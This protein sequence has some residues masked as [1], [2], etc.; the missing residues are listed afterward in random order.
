MGLDAG[1]RAEIGRFVLPLVARQVRGWRK[2]IATVPGP[3]VPAH[4]CPS[5]EAIEQA[6]RA[7][8]TDLVLP[9]FDHLGIDV[10]AARGWAE[11]GAPT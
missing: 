2:Q 4:G 3:A 11:A 6:M 10:R 7:S 8:I 1:G 5:G 9:G